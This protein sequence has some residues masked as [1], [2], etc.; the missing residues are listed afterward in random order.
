MPSNPLLSLDVKLGFGFFKAS[1]PNAPTFIPE[2][3]R[4]TFVSALVVAMEAGVRFFDTADIYA[5]S[6]D[7]MGHNELMLRDAVAQWDASPEEK[8][9]L[10]IATKGGITR[11]EGE[12]WGKNASY[13]YLLSAVE[14]SAARLGVEEIP[15]W[16]HHRLDPKLTLTEQLRNLKKL[17]DNAPIRHM[18]VSNYSKEQLLAALDAI[19]GPADGGII[20]V[21]N[22]L[23]PVYRQ[24]MDVIEVCEEHGLAYLPWSPT[25]GIRPNDAGSP[26]YELFDRLAVKH[27]VSTFAIA[28]AWLRSLSA[29]IIPMPGVTK[30]DSILDSLYAADL[31]LSNDELES[32][33]NLPTTLPLD[34]ELVRDQP[35]AAR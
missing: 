20:S 17:N 22:Q 23:N 21:Q 11:S 3:G 34:D 1:W 19:G 32:L 6:W 12:I 26:I 24:Q 7:Q 4:P 10:Q 28:Q 13:D 30:L 27:N 35:L 9:K 29:N 14:A 16:Q 15:I 5:P 33:A 2:T 31:R 25:K 8:A 18:G